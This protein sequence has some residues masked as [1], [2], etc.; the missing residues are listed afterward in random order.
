[1]MMTLVEVVVDV[2]V[3]VE[4]VVVSKQRTMV[5]NPL[6]PSSCIA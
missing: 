4:V 5:K 3:D 1:M 2:V 6:E